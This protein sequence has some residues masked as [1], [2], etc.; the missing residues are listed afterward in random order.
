M[1]SF[2]TSRKP[3]RSKVFRRSLPELLSEPVKNMRRE[4]TGNPS[5]FVPQSKCYESE[6]DY[7]DLEDEGDRCPFLW[8]STGPRPEK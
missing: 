2:N 6:Q 8:T 7:H 1:P 5:N 3:F 4:V